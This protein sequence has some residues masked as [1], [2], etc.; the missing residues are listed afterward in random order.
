MPTHHS[1]FQNWEQTIYTYHITYTIYA[2][3]PLARS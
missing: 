1:S 2:T 3:Y